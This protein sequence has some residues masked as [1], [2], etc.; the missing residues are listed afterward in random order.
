[1]QYN[2]G[3]ATVKLH[4]LDGALDP[5]VI[6]QAGYDAPGVVI[7]IRVTHNEITYPVFSGFVDSWIPD[8]T[9]PSLGWVTIS[10]TDGFSRLNTHLEEA[11]VAVGAGENLRSRII[12]LLD[13]AGWPADMRVL[14]AQSSVT[15]QATTFGGS[16]LD[17]I[18]EAVKAEIGDFYMQP[19]GKAYFRHRRSV[20]AE[21]RSTVSQVTFGS[22]RDLGEIPWVDKI[23][24]SW[25]RTTLKNKVIAGIAGSDNRMIAQDADS[26][27]RYGLYA[28]EETGLILTTDEAAQN[29]AN[30]VMRQDSRPEMRF[31]S[32]TLNGALDDTLGIPVIQHMLGRRMGDRIT[33]VRRP[34]AQPAGSIV[35]SREVLIRGIS[36][37]WSAS[38]KQLITK[39]ALAPTDKV[40]WF[41]LGSPTQGVLGQ[42]ALPY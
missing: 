34:P 40:P 25:D 29:W 8:Q 11:A 21:T 13:A 15:V 17:L 38:S 26:I 4:N 6:E 22:R 31:E 18:Q 27:G 7:R 10:A 5:Y 32:I 20:I 35:D 30:A 37:E 39:F 14:G 41:I 42:N 28:V 3:T 9:G 2:A 23:E 33:V 12:R 1:M 19:D 36:H 24:L 16:A